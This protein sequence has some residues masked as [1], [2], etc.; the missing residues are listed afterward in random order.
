MPTQAVLKKLQQLSKKEFSETTQRFFKTSAGSYGEKEKFL[1]IRVPVLRKFLKE[2]SHLELKHIEE[3]LHSEFNEMR[4]LALLLLV[5]RFKKSATEKTRRLI[6]K[7]YTKNVAHINNWNLVDTSA[8]YIMGAYLYDKDKTILYRWAEHSDLWHRR[9][10]M[11]ATWHDIR[12]HKFKDALA[13][14]KILLTD[15]EDLMHKAIGWMLREIGKKDQSVLEGFLN[16]H[17]VW[18]PRTALRYAI[19][20]FPEK[21]R[22]M[23]LKLKQHPDG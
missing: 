3:L 12:L 4:L 21:T 14:A 11:I 20:R 10:A 23:Y 16:K 19:E 8:H 18:M 17:A 9:I 7:I 22:K 13:I 15:T 1:G 2:C 5:E 6:Y